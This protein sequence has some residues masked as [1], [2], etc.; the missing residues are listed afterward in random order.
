MR[1]A[2]NEL[3]EIMGGATVIEPSFFMAKVTSPLP[4]IKISL[5]TLTLRW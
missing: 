3:L 5:P 2:Y 4:N 1:N